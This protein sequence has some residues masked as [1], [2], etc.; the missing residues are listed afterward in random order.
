MRYFSIAIAL[1]ALAGA[2]DSGN[3]EATAD[4]VADI[5][6]PSDV[7]QADVGSDIVG[8]VDVPQADVGPA[9]DLTQPDA[10]AALDPIGTY[11]MCVVLDL[12]GTLAAEVGEIVDAILAGVHAPTDFVYEVVN[13]MV[14]Y[15]ADAAE[16][17]TQLGALPEA[18]LARAEACLLASLDEPWL[19]D[20]EARA[21]TWLPWTLSRVGYLAELRLTEGAEA[22]AVTGEEQPLGLRLYLTEEAA[23]APPCEPSDCGVMELS[24]NELAALP[25][26]IEIG[27]PTWIANVSGGSLLVEPHSVAL[28]LGRVARL[29]LDR[30]LFEGEDG[31]GGGD[32]RQRMGLDPELCACIGGDTA[33][34][35]ALGA[36]GYPADD[37]TNVCG[38][39]L[40]TILAPIE[41]HLS[42]L[43][44]DS[45]LLLSGDATLLDDDGDGAVD[46]LDGGA[47]TGHVETPDGEQGLEV[48]ATWTATTTP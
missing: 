8:S 36:L 2:C 1:C 9:T 41:L 23:T 24:V 17:P 3:G 35:D 48:D 46:R 31:Q 43:S 40:D 44:A 47:L 25:F 33:V 19:R 42:A 27:Q 4:V 12:P 6:T 29:V 45:H 20:V 21:Q 39:L 7:V 18:L 14:E 11:D 16:D 32:L 5:V 13:R 38:T 15:Y 22:Y 34:V 26:P 30:I 37:A 28:N 10:G